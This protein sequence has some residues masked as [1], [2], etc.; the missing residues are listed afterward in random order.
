MNK[1]DHEPLDIGVYLKDEKLLHKN[2]LILQGYLGKE[3]IPIRLV[4]YR[5]RS[6]VINQ[7]LRAAN[8]QAR[9]KGETMSK[10]KRLLLHFAIF[11]TNTPEEMISSE[12]IGTVYRLRWEIELVFKR[13]KS[14]IGIDYLQGIHRERID[15]L[16]WS[17]LCTVLILELIVGY[18]KNTFTNPFGLELSEVKLIQYMMRNNEFCLALAKNRLESFFTQMEKDISKMLLKDKRMRKTMRERISSMENY[19]EMQLAEI[20]Q[21]A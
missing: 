8:K 19:Y 4:I 14:Q 10:S 11:V 1:E 3:K 18:F 21:I 5:L 2:V 6:E 16:I 17:R 9:K 12:M 15:C 20:Q 13:W 7:R